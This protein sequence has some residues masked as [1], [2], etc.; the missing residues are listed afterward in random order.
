MF[1]ASNTHIFF[2]L[3]WK[4][5]SIEDNTS[6]E[7]PDDPPE[8][9]VDAEGEKVKEKEEAKDPEPEKPK[10]VGD[11]NIIGKQLKIFS[12]IFILILFNI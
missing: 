12:I 7:K 11:E 5:I 4:Y 10:V 3:I 8:A 2:F 1:S 9:K 6:A